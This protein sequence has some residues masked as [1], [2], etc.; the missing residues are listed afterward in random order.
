M[1]FGRGFIPAE[2]VRPRKIEG[3]NEMKR[4]GK[5]SNIIDEICEYSNIYQSL[6]VVMRGT[7]RKKSRVGRWIMSHED[8]VI[9][10]LQEQIRAGTFRISGYREMLV[11]DGPKVRTV[12]SI[13]MIERIGCNAIMA[14]VEEKIFRRY[15][16]TTA[17]SIKRRGMHDLL[18]YI[19]RDL[20]EYPEEMRYAYKFDIR[21]FYESID[22][23]FMMYA[24]RRMFKD[25]VLL[26]I[27]ERFV[28]VMPKG[29]SIGLRSS[30]GFGNMLLGMFLDHY[31]KDEKGYRHFYRYCD[32]GDIHFRTK[33]EAWEA[34]NE[35][36]ERAALMKLEVKGNERVFPV[37]GGID[38]LGYVI[39]PTHTRLRKRNKQN[40]ARRLHKVKSKKR[41]QEIIAS[42]YGQCKHADCHN[43]FYRLTGIKMN[44]FKS[45]GIKPKFEDGKKR[46][47]GINVSVRELVNIPIEVVD[48][49]TGIVPRFEREEYEK[50][51][52]EAKAVYNAALAANGGK[53]PAGVIN[54]DDIEKPHGRY[55]VR[56]K[57]DGV[58]KKFFTA[59][60]EMWSILE[61][62]RE[63]DKFP[64]T[65]TIKAEMY[66]KKGETKY[67]FT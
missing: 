59:S 15:I 18:D 1:E 55:V 14:V 40:A 6:H 54:P 32:D 58:E 65:T 10:K 25:R 2:E 50:K 49:E 17:A 42:L 39:Y 48:F 43:L 13:P 19:R 34:R 3:K 12:Q 60:K 16:R 61:Q 21:K 27:L 23:D 24:L 20:E 67:I 66:G 46:F 35:I 26:T 62:V 38:F 44:D 31:L 53:V 37:T 36:H 56:I 51:V 47:K 29:L 11:T 28:R 52:A 57:A 8:E 30:Q 4:L 45:M 64:F 63:M 9:K 22:Q 7:K 41:R 5:T 33:K